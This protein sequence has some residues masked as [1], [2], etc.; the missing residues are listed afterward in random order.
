MGIVYSHRQDDAAIFAGQIKTTEAQLRKYRRRREE[1]LSQRESDPYC[2]SGEGWKRELPAVTQI[3]GTLEAQLRGQESSWR[4]S[5][6]N[7]DEGPRALTGGSY[8]LPDGA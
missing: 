5:G 8:W 6:G 4:A 1:L 3:I 2:A 7:V